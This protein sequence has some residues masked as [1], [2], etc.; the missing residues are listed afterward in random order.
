[1][2]KLIVVFLLLA[3]AA[4]SS[5]K[6][7][8]DYDSQADFSKYKTYSFT[9]EVAK[10][11]V[12]QLNRDR[13]I[14]AVETEMTAKGFTK[15]ES[16]PDM[17]V[18]LNVKTQQRTEATAT[19]TGGMYGRYGYG[20]GFSTTQVSYNQYVDGTLFVSFIDNTA[21]KIFWQGR[22]T[23]TIDED[24]SAEKREKNIS[25]AVKQIFTKY[26]PLKKK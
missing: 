11:P 5:L 20:G 24:A 19:N 15:S 4:C 18:D 9:E 16:S 10:L 2:K 1:M 21:Q 22:A 26:P 7:S 13:I 17:L 25:Y 6:V 23:K 12:D 8:S 3:F 14:K